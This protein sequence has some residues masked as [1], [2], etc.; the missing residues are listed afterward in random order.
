MLISLYLLDQWFSK[1]SYQ[2]SSSSHSIWELAGNVHSQ[3]PPQSLWIRHSRGGVRCCWC[4]HKFKNT[5]LDHRN[6]FCN[7]CHFYS[8]NNRTMELGKGV[9]GLM[10]EKD[11]WTRPKPSHSTCTGMQAPA[12][13]SPSWPILSIPWLPESASVGASGIPSE[14]NL[15]QTSLTWQDF[16]KTNKTKQKTKNNKPRFKGDES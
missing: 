6:W 1:E 9:S 14:T 8:Q 5:V 4:T 11:F 3:A 10:D 7:R 2:I 15:R 13:P 16:S 12:R